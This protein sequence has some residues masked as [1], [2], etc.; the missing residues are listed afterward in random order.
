MGKRWAVVIGAAAVGVM[1]LGAQMATAGDPDL[2]LSGGQDAE[3]PGGRDLR[4]R[5]LP[6]ACQGELWRRGVHRTRQG[7]ADEVRKA[8]DRGEKVKAKITVRA[9]DA[10][11]DV[12][13]AKRTIKLV[14]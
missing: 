4:S 9:T 5:F 1:A 14:K 10:A 8:L 6:G 7:E 2:Q 11:G 13:T 12:A 3:P